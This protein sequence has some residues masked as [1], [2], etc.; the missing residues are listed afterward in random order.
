MLWYSRGTLPGYAETIL[1]MVEAAMVVSLGDAYNVGGLDG[2]CEQRPSGY[3]LGPRQVA[4]R[5]EPTGA[6]WT[7][8]ATLR[9]GAIPALF[10]VPSH[11]VRDAVLDLDTFWG[12]G[13]ESLR[14]QIAEQPDVDRALSVWERALRARCD[15]NADLR[16]GRARVA[17]RLLTDGP[18]TS[19]VGGVADRIGMS[20]QH[21]ARELHRVA[22]LAPGE[23]RRLARFE[24]LVGSIDTRRPVNWAQLAARA[25][26]ADQSHMVRDFRSLAGLVPSAYVARRSL[27][28]GPL[29]PGAD[30][31]FVPEVPSVQDS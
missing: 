16:T 4:I 21:L 31:A 14:E 1:P 7:V 22:G 9:P 13:L 19:S 26:Y 11:A 30:A 20:R 29:A 24:Q 2:R 12:G 15:P 25:G 8:G 5:N 6:C 27:V 18:R 10:G 17:L 28:F 3:L 23:V